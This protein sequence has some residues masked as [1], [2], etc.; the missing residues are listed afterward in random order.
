MPLE[1]VRLG[2]AGAKNGMIRSHRFLGA[3]TALPALRGDAETAG[4]HARSSCAG[5]GHARSGRAA[6]DG[7]VDVVMRSRGVGHRFPGGTID[8]NEVWLEVEAL[9]ASGRVLARSSGALA[10]DGTLDAGAHLV[11]AQPVDGD[12]RPLARRDPQH[13]RGVAYDTSLSPS[14]PQAVR[15]ALPPA[16]R[17][18]AGAAPVSQ[19]LGGSMRGPRARPCAMPSCAVAACRRR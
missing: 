8:S 6:P 18:R 10:A 19:V 3:N 12:G 15:Y 2:D 16:T 9:D 13:M 7:A 11:R 17:A 5:S 4:A 14:D 1:P